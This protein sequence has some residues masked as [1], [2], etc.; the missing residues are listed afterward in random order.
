MATLQKFKHMAAQ[1]AVMGSSS[2]ARNPTTS[3]IV[4]RR[5]RHLPRRRKTLRMFLP[6]LPSDC[7][8]RSPRALPPSLPPND[9][10]ASR[11]NKDDVP[12]VAGCSDCRVGARVRHKLKDLLVSTSFEEEEREEVGEGDGD[13]GGREEVRAAFLRSS[14]IGSSVVGSGGVR[15]LRCRLM[16]SSWRP[17]LVAIPE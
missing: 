4:L 7:R 9:D 14:S 2:P 5:H 6:R 8:L 3:P 13:E 15:R 10:G 1:C 11:G 17:V 12:A 16:R